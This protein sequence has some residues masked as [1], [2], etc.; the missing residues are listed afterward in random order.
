MHAAFADLGRERGSGSGDPWAVHDGD[1]IVG[2]DRWG[3][4]ESSTSAGD[5]RGGADWAA[6]SGA[7]SGSA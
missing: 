7:V 4:G 5:P 3:S 1:Q 2:P 6:G